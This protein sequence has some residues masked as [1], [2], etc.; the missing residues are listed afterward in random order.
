MSRHLC[1]E[2]RGTLGLLLLTGR[3]DFIARLAFFF[4]RRL[5]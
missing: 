3:L 1:L 5:E 4:I 2:M